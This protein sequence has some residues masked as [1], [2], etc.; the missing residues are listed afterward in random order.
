MRGSAATNA[1][2]SKGRYSRTFTTPTFSPLAFIQSTDAAAF[3]AHVDGK[4]PAYA[5]PVFLRLIKAADTTGTFKY[6]KADLVADGLGPVTVCTD[7]LKPG[8]YAHFTEVDNSTFRT[9]PPL[10][11]TAMIACA[12]PRATRAAMSSAVSRVHRRS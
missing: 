12:S 2:A 8:G 10:R 4:L 7:L 9:V 11:V 6:R 5:Q 1:P 3:D